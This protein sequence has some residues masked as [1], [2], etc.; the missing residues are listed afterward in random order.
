MFRRKQRPQLAKNIVAE[1]ERIIEFG[2]DASYSLAS[3]ADR[4]FRDG[5]CREPRKVVQD[6]RNLRIKIGDR[7]RDG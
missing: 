3:T 1:S 4:A 5:L 7:E 2:Q 6:R